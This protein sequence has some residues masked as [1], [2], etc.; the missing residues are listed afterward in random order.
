M[1]SVGLL[2]VKVSP[3]HTGSVPYCVLCDFLTTK[4]YRCIDTG[5]K[6][7]G[8]KIQP[9]LSIL[10]SVKEESMANCKIDISLSYSRW[11]NGPIMTLSSDQTYQDPITGI[12]WWLQKKENGLMT[13]HIPNIKRMGNNLTFIIN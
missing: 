3:F 6:Y 10:F 5:I 2:V 11:E 9:E 1:F 12:N 8:G 13:L 7:K 4:D